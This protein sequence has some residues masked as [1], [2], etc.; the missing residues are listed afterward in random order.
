[1]HW[2][3]QSQAL[4]L[5]IARLKCI[6]NNVYLSQT[7]EIGHT[8]KDKG[9]S[10]AR[11]LRRD[12]KLDSICQSLRSLCSWICWLMLQPRPLLP[13]LSQSSSLPPAL[14]VQQA[15]HL[16]EQSSTYKLDTKFKIRS[17]HLSQIITSISIKKLIR[18]TSCYW[19][20]HHD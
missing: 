17:Q 1:M 8:K 3:N 2:S 19:N 4:R 9:I 6:F 14:P 16:S 10:W 7:L 5:A 20:L 12:W 11:D 18:Q 13:V 15:R